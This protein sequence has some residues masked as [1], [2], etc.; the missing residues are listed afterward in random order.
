VY[1]VNLRHLCVV[2]RHGRRSHGLR[3]WRRP[4][5]RDADLQRQRDAFDA[6]SGVT[7]AAG[8]RIFAENRHESQESTGKY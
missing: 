8:L 2:D 3:R 4:Q 5:Q 6:H 7:R 1:C